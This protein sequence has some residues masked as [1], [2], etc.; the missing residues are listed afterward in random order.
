MITAGFS[1][2]GC[3]GVP[4]DDVLL[5]AQQYRA[6]CVQ[7]RISHDEP[8]HT[9]L[10]A[11]QRSS[12]RLKFSDSGIKFAALATY[13]KLSDPNLLGPLEQHLQLASDLGAPALRIFP[14]D[15][16]PEIAIQRLSCAVTTA[17]GSGV[18][19]TLETH[20]SYLAGADIAA[21]LS[22]STA[23]AGAVW[24]VLHTWRSGEEFEDSFAALRPYLAELQIKDVPSKTD[25]RPVAPGNGEV[26]ARAAIDVAVAGGY[27]GPVIFEHEAKWRED[28][29][30][31]EPS[32]AAAM[33][34]I[35][36]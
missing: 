5:L 9:G 36:K 30:A 35:R 20:D 29:D 14:G 24:D 1:T 15:V 34:L 26:P 10:S 4:L 33:A 31:F 22:S 17:K 11:R 23:G 2:L 13:I 6:D 3:P 18:R 28:A 7:L 16:E 12:I 27:R 32:L 19:I 21:L 8:V 25:L